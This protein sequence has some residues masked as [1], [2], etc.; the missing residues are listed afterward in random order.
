MLTLES[1][2][3]FPI[4]MFD[5]CIL[6]NNPLAVGAP[7]A[8]HLLEAITDLL[9]VSPLNIAPLMRTVLVPHETRWCSH[10]CP[11]E[12]VHNSAFP[13]TSS[14]TLEGLKADQTVTIEN[15][16]MLFPEVFDKKGPEAL[17]FQ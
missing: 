3:G 12:L 6:I 16:W 17:C 8:L 15:Q 1:A 7:S 10:F 9:L 4:K 11:I 2:S 14:V 13:P 5:V